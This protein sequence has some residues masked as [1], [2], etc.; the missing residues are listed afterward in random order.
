VAAIFFL[1][2]KEPTLKSN[3]RSTVKVGFNYRFN[4]GGQGVAQY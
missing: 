1:E 2:A 4:L 3:F